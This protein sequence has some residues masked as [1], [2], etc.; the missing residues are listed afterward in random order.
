MQRISW[1][2]KILNYFE[3]FE[4][5]YR[6]SIRPIALVLVFFVF[7]LIHQW[8]ESLGDVLPN[9]INIFNHIG[10]VDSVVPAL[11]A[12]VVVGVF[13]TKSIK[14]SKKRYLRLGVFAG[15][16]VGLVCNILIELPFGMSLLNQPNIADPLDV[17]WGT[18][19]CLVAC[20]VFFTV[21]DKK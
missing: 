15:T 10:N 18:I 11:I 2:N 1:W 9:P 7:W 14:P 6:F 21:R 8:R 3:D 5:I 13:A 19:F 17:F 4:Q 12:G 16:L 20:S